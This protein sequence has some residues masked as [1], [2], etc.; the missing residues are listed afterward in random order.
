[1]GTRI[2]CWLLFYCQNQQI[3]ACTTGRAPG[4]L[5][6]VAQFPT[7]GFCKLTPISTLPPPSGHWSATLQFYPKA[8]SMKVCSLVNIF[9]EL[10]VD[11]DSLAMALT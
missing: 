3:P 8:I 7:C 10:S 1:M 9:T 6:T 11:M 2:P 4:L 5:G